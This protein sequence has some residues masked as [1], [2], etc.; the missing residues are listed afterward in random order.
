LARSANSFKLR[1]NV[2][3]AVIFDM[4]G[5][6]VDSHPVHKKAWQRFLDSVGHKVDEADLAFILDGRKK[7]DILKHFLGEL[8]PEEISRLGHEKELL[9]R[10]EA[11]AELRPVDGVEQLL[12]SLSRANIKLGVASSGSDG[13]VHF[14]LRTLRLLDYFSAIV[15]GDHVAAGKPDPAIFRLTSEK[16]QVPPDEILVFEDSLS[17]VKAAKAAGMRCVGLADPDRAS[18]LLDAGADRVIDHFGKFSVSQAQLLF[19]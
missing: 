19:A 11:R 13:R 2:L 6:L 15:A 7:E 3:Q 18:I 12:E 5:V 10:E 14:V 17:G 9:F 1:E 16:L 4:D 8:P